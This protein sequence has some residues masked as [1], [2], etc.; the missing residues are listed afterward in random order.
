MSKQEKIKLALA[1]AALL[2]AVLL[3]AW[4]FGWISF[5]SQAPPPSVPP[6]VIIEEPPPPAP[7][8]PT[9]RPTG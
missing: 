5:G 7:G 6:G 3:L 4:N 9:Q 1:I 2:G 8:T